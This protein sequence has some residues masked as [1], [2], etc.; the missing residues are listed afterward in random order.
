MEKFSILLVTALIGLFAAQVQ[1]GIST[2]GDVDPANPGTWTSS[3]WAYV[4]KTADG[5]MTINASSGVINNY[6][7]LGYDPGITGIATVTGAGSTWTNSSL[8]VGQNGTGILKSKTA[9]RC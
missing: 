4:G 1:A 6:G 3:T 7:Y 8:T 2:T 5:S 9:A